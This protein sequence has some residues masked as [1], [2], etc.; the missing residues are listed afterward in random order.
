MGSQ[1]KGILSSEVR[2]SDTLCVPRGGDLLTELYPSK[3]QPEPSWPCCCTVVH[4]FIVLKF[5]VAHSVLV[6]MVMFSSWIG[7]FTQYCIQLLIEDD[8]PPVS[9]WR[10]PVEFPCK[11]WSL[12][13]QR[14]EWET[15]CQKSSLVLKSLPESG[16]NETGFPHH[17]FCNKPLPFWH[18]SLPFPSPPRATFH[19]VHNTYGM[20]LFDVTLS[21]CPDLGIHLYW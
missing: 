18:K 12:S 9:V 7:V 5:S 4:G 19:A 14:R 6:D 21:L 10:L 3:L 2:V 15:S 20:V 11:C 17:P 16:N 13:Q 1:P 8:K